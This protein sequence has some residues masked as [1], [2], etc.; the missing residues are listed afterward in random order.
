MNLCEVTKFLD[1]FFGSDRFP[2]DPNGVYRASDRS[3]QRLGLALK[4]MIS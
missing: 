1:Q 4:P 3:V 2:D